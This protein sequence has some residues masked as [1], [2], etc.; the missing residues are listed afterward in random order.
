M[1]TGVD[2][3]TTY[4]LRLVEQCCRKAMDIDGTK[5]ENHRLRDLYNSMAY[6][7]ASAIKLG[8][9]KVP[10]RSEHWRRKLPK[11]IARARELLGEV[12]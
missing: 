5:E 2:G 9:G 8:N 4:A 12:G 6:D 3:T 1:P 10:E 7:L 11:V